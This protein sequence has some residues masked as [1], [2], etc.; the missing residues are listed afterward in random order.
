MAFEPA[1]MY[2]THYSKVGDV[3]RLAAL[4][5]SEIDETVALALSLRSA[6]DRHERL[7]AGLR[8][9]Y[10]RRV[11]EHGCTMPDERVEE[12]L[13]LDV[14]LNAQGLAIWLDRAARAAAVAGAV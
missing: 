11:R 9:L 2:L 3:P 4:L 6:E 1:C 8:S 5:L 12:L 13:A 14:E 7:Q 10:L